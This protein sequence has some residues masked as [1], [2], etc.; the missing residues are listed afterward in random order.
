MNS[1]LA[2]AFS[3]SGKETNS[4]SGEDFAKL[5]QENVPKS[6]QGAT[7]Q[8]AASMLKYVQ[9]GG[10]AFDYI[11][12]N[13]AELKIVDGVVTVTMGFYVW[14]SRMDLPYTLETT[15]GEISPVSV[16]YS[17]ARSFDILFRN[18]KSVDVGYVFEGQLTKQMQFYTSDGSDI[19]PDPTI[20]VKGST[21]Y[22]SKGA[23][24]VL[25]ADVVAK[26]YRH[27]VVLTL[28]PVATTKLD[29]ET[30]ATVEVTGYE[31]KSPAITVDWSS[32]N[33]PD[34]TKNDTLTMKIPKCVEDVL[35]ACPDASNSLTL[36][37]D[38]DNDEDSQFYF[39]YWNTC[40]GGVIKQFWSKYV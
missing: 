40:T 20:Y 15:V 24:T 16:E 1:S 29:K 30:G 8:D 6:S 27:T 25:R 23:S 17:E 32:D 22:L 36:N 12:D 5:E 38:K 11:S 19:S 10:N 21:V 18:T 37:K 3:G 39:V 28:N 2:I 13:C 35:E 33:N 34:E 9:Q 4:S 7:L 26:G 31:L 14:P